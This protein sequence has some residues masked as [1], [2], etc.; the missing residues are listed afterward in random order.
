MSPEQRSRALTKWRKRVPLLWD[1]S[2]PVLYRPQGEE[3]GV[4]ELAL[5]LT[6]LLSA[7]G[8]SDRRLGEALPAPEDE[9]QGSS[10]KRDQLRR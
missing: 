9:R 4:I 2:F 3:R 10:A 5:G 7:L 1:G 6:D 8:A